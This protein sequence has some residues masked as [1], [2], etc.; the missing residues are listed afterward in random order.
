MFLGSSTSGRRTADGISAASVATDTTGF[1]RL[2][3]GG[4]FSFDSSLDGRTNSAI[5]RA[6]S[7]RPSPFPLPPHTR[8]ANDPLLGRGDRLVNEM[9]PVACFL[10]LTCAAG[11]MNSATP[12]DRFLQ[13]P[14]RVYP[15]QG[16]ASFS[17]YLGHAMTGLFLPGLF[18]HLSELFGRPGTERLELWF[19]P[20][21]VLE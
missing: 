19:R 1:D 10:P 18:L 5:W 7:V 17:Y 9:Q 16:S 8:T 2:S 12:Q 21:R 3:P 13:R 15:A 4:A 11:W 20:H 6:T 14:S